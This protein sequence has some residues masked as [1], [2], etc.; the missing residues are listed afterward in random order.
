MPEEG[1][2]HVSVAPD[3]VEPFIGKVGGFFDGVGTQVGR[4]ARHE[5]APDKFHKVEVIAVGGDLLDDEPFALRSDPRPPASSQPNRA[6]K[7]ISTRSAFARSEKSGAGPE[8]A[9]R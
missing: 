1:E 2:A 6:R 5:V 9:R 7:R 3:A 8:D 4:R